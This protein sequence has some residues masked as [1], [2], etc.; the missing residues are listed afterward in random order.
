M[1]FTPTPHFPVN[2]LMALRG[3]VAMQMRMPREFLRYVDLMFKAIWEAHR[4]FNRRDEIA[5]A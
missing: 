3:A 4:D 1:P 5:A 2:S